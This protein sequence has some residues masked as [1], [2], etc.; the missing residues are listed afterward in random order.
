MC[1]LP[2]A[3]LILLAIKPLI[4]VRLLPFV[5]SWEG[6]EGRE[7][8]KCGQKASSCGSTAFNQLLL[9]LFLCNFLVSQ[10]CDHSQQSGSLS[11][12]LRPPLIYPSF[13]PSSPPAPSLFSGKFPLAYSFQNSIA[14]VFA[15]K[16][17]GA[18]DMCQAP[19][20]YSWNALQTHFCTLGQDVRAGAERGGEGEGK[21][22]GGKS[23][24]YLR[25]GRRESHFSCH[26]LT[27]RLLVL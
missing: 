19:S 15:V 14:P 22:E 25:S 11:Y 27:R 13:V 17:F 1:L 24:N 8:R 7:E 2:L 23:G 9:E 12:R 3:G 4:R 16:A 18:F 6:E 21:R 26:S 5:R 10:K 20:L